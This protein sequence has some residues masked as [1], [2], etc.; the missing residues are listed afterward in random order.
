MI[1]RP[2]RLPIRTSPGAAASQRGVSLFIALI[3]LVAMTLAGLA[4]IRTV[5][6]G[7]LLS[8][9]LAFRKNAINS[10]EAGL[11]TAITWLT[12]QSASTLE[13]DHTSNAYFA[14][15]GTFNPL[16][17]NWSNAVQVSGGTADAA[18]N[19]IRYVIHRMCVAS[20]N[21]DSTQC[22]KALGTSS[23][24]PNT[25]F[26]YSEGGGLTGSTK[27]YFRITAQVLGPRGTVSYLQANIY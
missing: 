25:G 20:G 15:W 16:T 8:G 14:S 7:M 23:G 10:A 21:P 4:V 18:G 12:A 17:F 3:A 24:T 6:T 9:N 2:R 26:D 27:V 19:S 5:D 11:E 22:V 1:P 13:T